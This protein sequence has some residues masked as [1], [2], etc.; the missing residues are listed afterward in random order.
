[1]WNCANENKHGRARDLF[2]LTGLTIR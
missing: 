1:V 2:P